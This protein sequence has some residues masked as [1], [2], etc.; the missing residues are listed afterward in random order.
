MVQYKSMLTKRTQ[1]MRGKTRGRM[2]YQ[3]KE[4]IPRAMIPMNLKTEVKR[5]SFDTDNIFVGGGGIPTTVNGWNCLTN[6]ILGT[7]QNQRIGK[8]I[9]IRYFQMTISIFNAS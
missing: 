9:F 8:R 5:I 1:K 2:P 4:N 7:G 6:C 3:R